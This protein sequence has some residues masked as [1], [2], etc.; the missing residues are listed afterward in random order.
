M[1][2]KGAIQRSGALVALSVTGFF[3]SGFAGGSSF[4]ETHGLPGAI[5]IGGVKTGGFTLK[6]AT[7]AVQTAFARPVPVIIAGTR[8]E[9]D[10]T[11]VAT[12]DV[13]K[14]VNAAQKAMPGTTVPLPV[15]VR[16]ADLA[17]AV[18]VLSH[19]YRL[20]PKDAQVNLMAGR[21][22]ITPSV[23]GA[24]VDM[25]VLVK[26]ITDALTSNSRS[27]VVAGVKVVK[28]AITTSEIG[29]VI[30]IN[31]ST[32]KLTLYD[33]HLKVRRIF[34]VATGQP[35][36]PTPSGKFSIVN[37]A[38]NPWWTPPSSSWARGLKPVPPG[39]G[40]P[41]GTRW[42]GLSSPGVGIHGTNAPWSIGTNASHSCIRMLIPQVE[43]LYQHAS[44]GST[45][46]IV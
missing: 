2:P 18:A 34:G 42:M 7:T 25:P 41:L 13:D 39:P 27:P 9:L 28:P 24:I 10:P 35:A 43:W 22:R 19:K 45:V 36:Y 37:K 29:T 31:R 8:T 4:A 23:D 32:N 11:A 38:M 5:K 33:A 17:K 6:E 46:F 44:V 40:N 12:V 16:T 20:A 1:S 21:P 3:V 26:Q 15:T 30:V 14:A